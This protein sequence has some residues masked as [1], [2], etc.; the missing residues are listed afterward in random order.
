MRFSV[1]YSVD[2]PG[3][4]PIPVHAPPSLDLWEETQG[5]ESYEY[6]YLE[7]R[8]TKG[9]HRQ[10]ASL[11]N[12]TPF[13]D[14]VRHCRLWAEDVQT[15]GSIGALGFGVGWAPAISF[16]SDDQDAIKSA[17]V[18]PIPTLRRREFD[19]DDWERVRAAVLSVY[20]RSKR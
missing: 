1:I 2:V 9:H 5:D 14:F 15:L 18:T 13:D 8:W 16:T 17:Y 19:E 7:G 3:D 20:G 4:D 11:L 6:G 12:R 10:W